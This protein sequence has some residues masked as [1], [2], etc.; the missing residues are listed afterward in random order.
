MDSLRL[1]TER[2]TI[3]DWKTMMPK[4]LVALLCF[5]VL[6]GAGCASAQDRSQ[7]TAPAIIPQPLAISSG[8]GSFVLSDGDRISVP[9]GDAVAR[10][11]ADRFVDLM[12]R[13][14][15]LRLTVTET[16]N[17]KVRL[18]RRA[19]TEAGSYELDV[20]PDGVTIS[21]GDDAGLQYGLVTLWQLAT[22]GSGGPAVIEAV[23]I[24]DAPRFA[25][26]GVMLDSARHY[27]SP[28]F[29]KGFLDWMA[30]HKL[31]VFHWHL[32]DD[33]AWR[34]EIRA[35][36]RLTEVGAW[37]VPEGT[38]ARND[39]DPATGQ[40]RLYGGFYTQ[41]Q[42][43]EIVAH[44]AS[45]GITVVPEI[46]VPGH[47]SAAVAAYPELGVQDA[48]NSAV[49]AVPSDWGVYHT[50]F[51]TR[52]ETIAFLTSVLDEVMDLF[53]GQYIHLGGDEAVKD[54]WKASPS[55]QAHMRALG[56]TDEMQ[57][58]GWFMSQMEAHLNAHGRRMIGWDE[59]LEG[60]LEG[61]AA[62]MSW[63]GVEGAI[64]AARLG[65]DTVL[66]PGPT[67]YF[68]YRQS[69]NDGAP[70]RVTMSRMQD[71]Y[72][73][74][75]WAGMTPEQAGHVLGVQGN[76][77]TEHM[78]DEGRVEYM[79]YPRIAALAELAWSAPERKQFADFNRRLDPQLARY[80]TLGID[81]AESALDTVAA[82]PP[83]D[84]QRRQDHQM[85]LCSNAIGLTLID[86]APIGG[87]RA[88][89]TMDI[90]NPC[91][92]YQQA[93][94]THGASV[95]VAVGQV[96]FNFQIG[97][98]IEKVKVRPATGA[99]GD[100][101]VRADGCEGPVVLAISLTDAARSDS[102]TVLDGVLPKL[103]GRHDLCLTFTQHGIDPMWG[104]DWVELSPGKGD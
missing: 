36:P 45:L 40:P 24:A 25:W 47:A 1:L 2:L 71:I 93:D 50:L 26:R 68:D 104:L 38:A 42:V 97:A 86:D 100:L 16:A 10:A 17:G 21:A 53:P 95:K 34:L 49:T 102:V 44:A 37:R 77:F 62:V 28:E 59:I 52:P 55:V 79:A 80:R 5:A 69:P 65:H 60:G 56:L 94:L 41:E 83:P 8:Q 51:N 67:F 103:P 39:L 85:T 9:S 91:W 61:S 15:D 74:D 18:Q 89:F 6:A 98:D 19:A 101:E 78:I 43:R 11:H 20:E 4:A 72:D 35:H 7:A 23:R 58:Q 92:I 63:R 3:A 30:L 22:P 64:E 31:N 99:V 87:E 29:I 70:G 57:M 82:P 66:T 27:Q 73:F 96:P 14:R 76:I 46:D 88:G 75:P 81:Y 33:Q 84:G 32:T 54:Q 12:A 48:P 90:M 13:T